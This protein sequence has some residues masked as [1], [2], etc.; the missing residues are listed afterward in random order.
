MSGEAEQETGL[1][2]GIAVGRH[3]QRDP[4]GN[5]GPVEADVFD[6]APVGA[7]DL[8]SGG[9]GERM[10]VYGLKMGEDRAIEPLLQDLQ[11]GIG[12]GDARRSGHE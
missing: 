2:T 4:V 9:V 8:G 6:R 7:I 3:R 10:R 11:L 5:A 12:S 1:V